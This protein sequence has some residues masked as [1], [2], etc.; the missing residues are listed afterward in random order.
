M[1]YSLKKERLCHIYHESETVSG[2]LSMNI[3]L[4]FQKFTLK[5]RPSAGAL[6][7]AYFGSRDQARSGDYCPQSM[8]NGIPFTGVFQTG[9]K[10]GYGIKCCIIFNR[11]LTW[12]T[13]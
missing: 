5:M 11:M 12:S 2:L 10:K 8:A 6:L 1:R 4:N 9:P 13:S 3:Y 7:R